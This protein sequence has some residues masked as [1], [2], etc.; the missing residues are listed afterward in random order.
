MASSHRE[1]SPFVL[2]DDKMAAPL[3][4]PFKGNHNQKMQKKVLM[5]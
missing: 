2:G 3:V 4:T 5:Y 1:L